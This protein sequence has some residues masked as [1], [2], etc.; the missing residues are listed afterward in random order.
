MVVGW[1]GV[2]TLFLRRSGTRH[3]RKKTTILSSSWFVLGGC[4]WLV[5]SFLGVGTLEKR[6]EKFLGVSSMGQMPAKMGE[7]SAVHLED[8]EVFLIQCDKVCQQFPLLIG[9]LQLHS[10]PYIKYIYIYLYLYIDN[11]YTK[12]ICKHKLSLYDVFV[13][14]SHHVHTSTFK[15]VPNGSVTGCQLTKG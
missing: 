13:N 11:K 14:L 2:S 10:L 3:H 4:H 6:L 15:G 5:F 12:M 9:M 8:C 7:M 1:S